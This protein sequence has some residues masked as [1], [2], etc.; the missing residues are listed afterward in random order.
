MIAGRDAAT[1]G[2][3]KN[4]WLTGTAAWNYVAITQWILGI[5]PTYTGLQ[6][7]PTIPKR[8]G[9]FTVTRRFRGATYRIS[10]K[11]AGKGSRAAIR[12]DG[13]VQAGNI[14]PLPRPGQTEIEVEVILKMR[15][16]YFDDARREYVITNPRLPVKWINYIGTLGFG[17]FVDHN[18]GGVI[19]KGDPALNRLTFYLIQLPAG[20]FNGETLYLRFKHGRE[21]KSFSPFFVP[22]LDPSSASNATSA[23]VIPASSPSSTTSAARSQFSSRR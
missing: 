6:I 11:R 5:H 12:V 16:G 19:C 13:Q 23:W 7:S 21:I 8:W 4:S 14:L 2:E 18:G 20:S 17:G 15:Y 9:S 1:H 10:V 3:A 22:T